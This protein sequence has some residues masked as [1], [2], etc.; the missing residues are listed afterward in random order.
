[1][2]KS[3]LKTFKNGITTNFSD[4]IFILFDIFFQQ[5]FTHGGYIGQTQDQ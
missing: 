4:L 5:V 2:I 1:M 3:S